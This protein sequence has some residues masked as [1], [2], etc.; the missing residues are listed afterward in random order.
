[1]DSDYRTDE[2]ET[3][4]NSVLLYLAEIENGA[5]FGFDLVESDGQLL[6]NAVDKPKARQ[7][8]RHKNP[9]SDRPVV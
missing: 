4:T 7:P 2:S 3:E 9:L 1:M 5:T 6:L 8:H